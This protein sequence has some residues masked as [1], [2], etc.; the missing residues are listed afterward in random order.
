VIACGTEFIQHIAV[1]RGFLTETLAFLEAHKIR[2][3]VR[4]ERYAGTQIEAA[5]QGQLHPLQQDAVAAWLIA[6]RK[7]NSLI[8]VHRQQLLDQWQERLS[9]FLDLPTKSIGI[10]VAAKWN[11][12]VA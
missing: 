11:G 2:P 8:V 6:E 4:D 10:S 3:D 1:P 7:V 9:M 12:Q 5:F